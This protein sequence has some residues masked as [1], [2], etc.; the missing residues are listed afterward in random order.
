MCWSGDPREA[1]RALAP[2]ARLRTPL[3]NRIK[4]IAYL[5]I[6]KDRD[7]SDPQN[8]IEERRG[9]ASKTGFS[10]GFDARLV[11]ALLAVPA[12]SPGRRFGILIQ[13]AGGEMN[14]VA[15]DATAFPHR[16]ATHVISPV[17]SW[18]QPGDD[19]AHRRSMDEY[20]AKVEPHTDGYY[21]N[22]VDRE[23]DV[24]EHNYRGNL[25]RLRQIKNRYDP[26]N[27]FRLNANIRPTV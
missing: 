11:D 14:Q 20:W 15:A 8:R 22:L 6:Q 1:D 10:N 16:R 7:R 19:A 25:V 21:A 23:P 17:L 4:T 13:H 2:L 9:F 18:P 12:E 27:L 24:V 3:E 5:A 26:T